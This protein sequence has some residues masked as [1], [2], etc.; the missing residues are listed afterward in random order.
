MTDKPLPSEI[1]VPKEVFEVILKHTITHVFPHRPP[2]YDP[3]M[4]LRDREKL[5]KFAKLLAEF[6]KVQDKTQVDLLKNMEQQFKIP[7]R[8]V[9]V[10]HN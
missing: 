8:P 5:A 2:I 7:A 3:V 9:E 4:F 6:D 1:T 10:A